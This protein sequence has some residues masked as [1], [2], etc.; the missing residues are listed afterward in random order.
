MDWRILT[1]FFFFL[2]FAGCEQGL[3]DQPELFFDIEAEFS[4]SLIE[5]L[6]KNGN[7][8]TV[9]LQ[10]V[11]PQPCNDTRILYELDR[12]GEAFFLNILRL[13][14][15]EPCKEEPAPAES[16]VPL[17]VLS[18]S[19]YNFSVLLQSAIENRGVLTVEAD[20]YL[21]DLET[22]NGVQ[23]AEKEL[24]R[25]LPQMIWGYIDYQAP[26]NEDLAVD[27]LGRLSQLVSFSEFQDGNYGH[28]RIDQGS[29]I[30]EEAG[31]SE[32]VYTFVHSLKAPLEQL[33]ETLNQFR[34][35]HSEMNL[36]IVIYTWEGERL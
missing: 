3:D 1:G 8:L 5:E 13:L 31:D 16:V 14:E 20:R 27:F 10:T 28:F 19:D 12:Q 6:D 36:Q 34:T 4:L 21:L 30:L 9:R 17:G 25:I 32:Q 29:C 18:P 11:K 23:V 22:E 24:R 15:P 26:Q 35:E 33:T 2:I 7:T